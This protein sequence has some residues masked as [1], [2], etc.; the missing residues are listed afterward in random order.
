[1]LKGTVQ[2][3]NGMFYTVISYEDENG[4]RK[5]KWEKTGLAVKGNKRRAEELLRQRLEEFEMKMN[6]TGDEEQKPDIPFSKFMS[7][8]ICRSTD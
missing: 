7:Y 3:K 2:N 1:M 5:Q 4:K 6:N 8:T